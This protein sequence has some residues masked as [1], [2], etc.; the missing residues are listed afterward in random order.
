MNAGAE[1]VA[2][3]AFMKGVTVPQAMSAAFMA[4]TIIM[5]TIIMRTI[6]MRNIRAA[7]HREKAIAPGGAD[8]VMRAMGMTGITGMNGANA[9]RLSVPPVPLCER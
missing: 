7:N 4:R 9:V 8:V 6:I 2:G 5:R 3:R 1:A